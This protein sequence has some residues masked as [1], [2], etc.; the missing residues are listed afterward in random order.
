MFLLWDHDGVLV[1]T[2]YWYFKA[3]QQKLAEG[4]LH[5]DQAAWVA[6]MTTGKSFW[7]RVEEG[8]RLRDE[9]NALYQNYLRRED[10]EIDGVVDVLTSLGDEH[11]MA[12]VTTARRADFELIHAQRDIRGHFDFVLT[13]EDYPRSKPAPDP[14]LTALERF[15]AKADDA[16][17]IEDSGRGLAAAVAAGV[18]CVIV[19]NAFTRSHDF[20]A[21][22]RIVEHIGEVPAAIADG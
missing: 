22:W 3:T 4:G 11:S 21:A 14:Y 1:D 6:N 15:G 9:R 18:R 8:A 19:K 5:I 16:V 12:I 2:E 13:V 7:D 10:I 20:S 17:V